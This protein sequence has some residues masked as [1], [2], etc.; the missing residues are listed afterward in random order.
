M[1]QKSPGKVRRPIAVDLID[2]D[3]PIFLEHDCYK[4][5]ADGSF[6]YSVLPLPKPEGDGWELS[7][8][9]DEKRCSRRR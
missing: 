7:Y 9:V 6:A 1:P 2:S 3:V 4:K 8:R 5:H